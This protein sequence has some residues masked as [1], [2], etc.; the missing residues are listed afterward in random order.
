MARYVTRVATPLAADAAFAYLADLTNFEHWDPGVRRSVQV[1]GDGPGADAAYDVTVAATPRDLTLRYEVT[2]YDPPR[3][4]LVV[5]RNA[6]LTS[7]DRITVVPDGDGSIVTYDADLALNGPLAL[8]DPV[9]RLAFGRIGDRAAA[10]LR[11][12]LD[13]EAV[14]T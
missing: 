4:C 2:R 10:G 12:A 7:T 6:V 11:R 3:V 9:L 14:P 5:A 1:A 8:F 13:G